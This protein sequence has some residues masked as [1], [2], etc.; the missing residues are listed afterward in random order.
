MWT[1]FKV[2]FTLAPHRLPQL[3]IPI[4]RKRGRLRDTVFGQDRPTRLFG[5]TS[6]HECRLDSLPERIDSCYQQKLSTKLREVHPSGEAI[7]LLVAEAR[8]LAGLENYVGNGGRPS[9]DKL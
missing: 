6:A 2:R 8:G 4:S 9:G 1:A 7:S 5:V 3:E